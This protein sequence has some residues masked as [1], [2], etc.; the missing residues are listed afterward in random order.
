ME[1]GSYPVFA[2]PRLMS[3]VGAPFPSDQDYNAL[4]PSRILDTRDGTG[5]ARAAVRPGES[6]ALKVLGEGGVPASGVG[7]VVLNTTVTGPTSSGYIT[8]WPSGSERP[9]ASNLNFVRGLTVPNLV[10]VPVGPDG[11]VNLYNGSPGSTHLI[12][13]VLGY[14]PGPVSADP[15]SVML[16]EALDRVDRSGTWSERAVPVQGSTRFNSVAHLGRVSTSPRWVEYNLSRR[17]GTLTTTLSFDDSE[18]DADSVIRFRILGD[19]VAARPDPAV[20]GRP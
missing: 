16:T 6:V 12:A 2:D 7:S 4:V 8:V 17:W 3:A 9:L 11:F 14:F 10:I 13:D 19:G 1:R 18:G 5:A 20:R 15:A